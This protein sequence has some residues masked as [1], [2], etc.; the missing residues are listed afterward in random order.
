MLKKA[1]KEADKT[2]P[3]SKE[4][5]LDANTSAEPAPSTRKGKRKGETEATPALQGKVKPAAKGDAKT[6]KAQK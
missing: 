1:D 4:L 6:K 5:L 3:P 2:T